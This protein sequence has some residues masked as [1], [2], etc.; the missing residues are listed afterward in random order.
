MTTVIGVRFKKA[1]KVYYFDPSEVWP[2]AG[3]Q[4]VVETSR[5]VELGEVIAGARE[6]DDDQI[7]SPLKKVIR[8][9]TPEDLRR[10]EFNRDRE[11]EARR[12]C[13]ERIQHHQLEMKLVDVEY[14]FDGS[15]II[16]YFTAN[17]RVDFRELVKD[18]ASVFKMRIELRQIG[19]RDEAKMLGGLGSCGRPICCGAFLGD[20]QPVSIKMAKEQNLSLNPT[21]ISGQ[22]GRLMCCL[23]YEQDHYEA[24]LKRL[25]RVGREGMTPDG[26]GTI[27]DINVIR[28]RVRARVRGEGDSYDVREYPLEEVSKLQHAGEGGEQR[29]HQPQ[30]GQPQSGEA[31][32]QQRSKPR[33]P[34]DSQP[35]PGGA[36]GHKEAAQDGAKD[37]AK[38][39]A[40]DKPERPR[41]RS[42][43][44]K[45]PKQSTEQYFD[46]L[47]NPSRPAAAARE[48]TGDGEPDC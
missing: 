38:D 35:K 9:A 25:P 37:S 16:F 33:P 45:A 29:Q 17:G 44:P 48:G 13:H 32:P 27:L 11:Q 47:S 24:A 31:G 6:V 26:P 4:V 42:T 22:C 36:K 14:T 10:A 19:V 43:R 41:R 40:P 39:A 2:K 3:D 8:V 5:G 46:K 34:K 30:Q 21:K 23:K 12:V 7:V 18:L 15:K 1:G 28:E 20:F